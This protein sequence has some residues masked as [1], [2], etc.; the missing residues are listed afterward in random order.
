MNINSRKLAVVFYLF[1]VSILINTSAMAGTDTIKISCAANLS[2]ALKKIGDHFSK[3]RPGIEIQYNFGSSG[4]LA[5]QIDNGAPADIFISASDKWMK[6]LSTNK[7]I[8]QTSIRDIAGNSL[9]VVSLK[10]KP[11]S[12]LAHINTCSRIAIGSP[13]S[14]PVGEYTE[15]ALRASGIYDSLVSQNKLVLTKDVRQALL[16]ADRGEADLAFV[17]KTDALLAQNAKI[18]FTVP[19]KLHDPIVFSMA[20]TVEGSTRENVKAFF[21]ALSSNDAKTVLESFG[22]TTLKK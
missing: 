1:M 14:T 22:Y 3:N 6:H 7:K 5:K 18:V 13:G 8:V 12:S 4:S 21:E 10:A 15:Q 11:F 2:D 19:T 9:V 20:L 16:Y 17:Y